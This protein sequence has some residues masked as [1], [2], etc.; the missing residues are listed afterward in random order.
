[1]VFP[2]D[3]FFKNW[4]TTKKVK[5]KIATKPINQL[6]LQPLSMTE[7]QPFLGRFEKTP[8][9]WTELRP[10][11]SKSTAGPP[12]PEIKAKRVLMIH[13][14]YCNKSYVPGMISMNLFQI[15]YNL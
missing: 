9:F 15:L 1:M 14:V 4:E 5:N 6:N 2:Q 3:F 8:V 11:V 12:S 10:L 13:V 7:N